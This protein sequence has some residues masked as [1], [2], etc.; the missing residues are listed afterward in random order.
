MFHYE[1]SLIQTT[2]R[3]YFTAASAI[4]THNTRTKDDC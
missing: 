4:P 3:D 1:N 2:F